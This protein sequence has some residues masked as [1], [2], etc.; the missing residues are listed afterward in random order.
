VKFL[1]EGHRWQ[2]TKWRRN[3][4]GN[5]NHLSRAHERY[6]QTTDRRMTTYSEREHTFLY[7][8]A[9]VTSEAVEEVWWSN[10]RN[11]GP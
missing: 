2:G 9:A 6:R 8:R 3:I 10:I 7:G 1:M 4:A 5:F 11:N